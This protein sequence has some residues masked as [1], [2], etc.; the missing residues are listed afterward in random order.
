MSSLV[1]KCLSLAAALSL[2][3]FSSQLASANNPQE[4]GPGCR[5]AG[6]SAQLGAVLDQLSQRTFVTIGTIQSG[7]F[8]DQLS[9][10]GTA[11]TIGGFLQAPQL[12]GATQTSAGFI[13]LV[14]GSDLNTS[15]R[16]LVGNSSDAQAISQALALNVPLVLEHFDA[17]KLKALSGLGIPLPSVATVVQSLPG[18]RAY[19]ITEIDKPKGGLTQ[20]FVLNSVNRALANNGGLV[21]SSIAPSMLPYAIKVWDVWRRRATSSAVSPTERP[22]RL[23]RLET[24]ISALSSPWLP[25]TSRNKR[26]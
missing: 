24:S 12:L 9:T 20:D 3:P 15:D 5:P 22:P 1:S 8:L 14:N 7:S 6:D 11:G 18:S 4:A 23:N 25:E 17:P 10:A 21:G 13:L 26:L 2:A 19:V 16:G